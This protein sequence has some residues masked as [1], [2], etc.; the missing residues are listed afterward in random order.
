MN[1]LDLFKFSL[2]FLLSLS[3]GNLALGDGTCIT[4]F[5]NLFLENNYQLLTCKLMEN[6]FFFFFN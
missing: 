6:R 5:Q 4:E 3:A 1:A 2:F